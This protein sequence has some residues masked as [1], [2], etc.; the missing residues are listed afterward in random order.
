VLSQ[1]SRGQVAWGDRL[2]RAWY[3]AMRALRTYI[4][5]RRRAEAVCWWWGL[6]FWGPESGQGLAEEAGDRGVGVSDGAG[7]CYSSLVVLGSRVERPA[8]RRVLL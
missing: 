8:G 2:E 7:G 6:A 5:T 1:R 3:T 4:V